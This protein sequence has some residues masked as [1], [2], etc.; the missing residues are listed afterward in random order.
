MIID[1]QNVG[2]FFGDTFSSTT[3]FTL[4]HI[5]VQSISSFEHLSFSFSSDFFT[6][7]LDFTLF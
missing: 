1:Q 7:Q 4:L 2:T 3:V 6:Y 5:E